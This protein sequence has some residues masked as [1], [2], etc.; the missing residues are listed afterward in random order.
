MGIAM[1]PPPPPPLRRLRRSLWIGAGATA[2]L[3]ATLA[4]IPGAAAFLRESW[5]SLTG[6]PDGKPSPAAGSRQEGAE[7]SAVF[8]ICQF[9]RF[10]MPFS[11]RLSAFI[12]GLAGPE[13]RAAAQARMSVGSRSV[14]IAQCD[15]R[16]NEFYADWDPAIDRGAHPKNGSLYHDRLIF[17]F[18]LPGASCTFSSTDRQSLRRFSGAIAC[19]KSP[20]TLLQLYRDAGQPPA[21]VDQQDAEFRD[22]VSVDLQQ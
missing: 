21:H 22:D 20:S 1:T 8:S 16:T 11:D 15:R 7:G 14:A 6:C 4:A 18:R 10:H 13:G 9:G 17:S 12:A 19:R 3:I 2:T 5:C